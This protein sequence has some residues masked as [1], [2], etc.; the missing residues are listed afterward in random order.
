MPGTA[1]VLPTPTSLQRLRAAARVVTS[2]GWFALVFG[3]GAWIVGWQLGW[4]EFT[5]IAT[6]CGACLVMAVMFVFGRAAL[7]VSVRLQP[8]RV[9]VGE[10]AAG[11]L[12]VTNASNRR[13]LPL[14]VELVVGEGA[15]EFDVPSLAAGESH[16]EL[17]VLP[18][19]RRAVIPVG[20]ATSVRGDP[21]GLLRRAVPWTE[22]QPLFVHPRTVPLGHL[23]AGLLRDLEG[24]PTVDL[25]PS[26]IAFHALREYEPGDDRR[27][28]HWLTT[29]RVGRLMVR[30][31]TDT[32]RAHLAVVVDGSSASYAD[33][34]EFETAVS[35][36]AS[37]GVRAMSDEQE[38]SMVVGG[39]RISCV[40]GQ[41]MLDGL[42]GVETRGRGTSLVSQVDELTRTTTGVSLAMV[43]TGQRPSIADLRAAT[44]RFAQDVRTVVV[45]VEPGAATGFRPVGS[46]LVLTI[47]DL[48]ELSRLLWAVGT[49]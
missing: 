15:A 42:A 43:V 17:F 32:R 13:L 30:Q 27:F 21:L 22:P 8:Q 1:D 7:D 37:L 46:T 16:D 45:R 2:A 47:G 49:A 6:A 33:P 39:R 14:Q 5:Y 28:V 25:S 38:L 23:G 12:E 4:H 35:V 20:P 36:A 18:T 19:E 41:A 29:A 34:D 44:V 40:T 48:E 26:D 10:R 3:A 31:F 9:V 24:Q 11:E